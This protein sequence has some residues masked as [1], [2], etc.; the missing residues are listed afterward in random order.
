MKERL[1]PEHLKDLFCL[2]F[3]FENGK[4]YE[5]PEQRRI[6]NFFCVFD[7]LTD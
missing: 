6:G 7:E 5:D 2:L 1:I 3:D 4:R